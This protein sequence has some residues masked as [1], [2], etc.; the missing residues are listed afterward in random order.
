MQNNYVAIYGD[1]ER[2]VNF[3]Q[4]QPTACDPGGAS[5]ACATVIPK[6]WQKFNVGYFPS[7]A[8]VSGTTIY[9]PF[10]TSFT[11]NTT[12]ATGYQNTYTDVN[13]SYN[14]GVANITSNGWLTPG[15]TTDALF[16]SHNQQGTFSAKYTGTA[17]GTNMTVSGITGSINVG[18]Y[19]TDKCGGCGSVPHTTA[20]KITGTCGANCWV[21][22]QS[23]TFSGQ[24]LEDFLYPGAITS[25]TI[26]GN[27]FD[28]TGADT[29][30][31][32]DE[33]SVYGSKTISGNW[34]PTSGAA[35]NTPNVSC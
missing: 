4:Q 24:V 22:N 21:M 6:A 10:S 12:V 19:I 3:V 9:G 2:H 1:V 28:P 20:I 26:V 18:D 27:A 16:A 17:S 14:I 5:N 8:A 23:L 32:L 30:I 33:D 7:Y 34:N 31:S 11:A 35:C 29:A 13:S 25:L 15:V